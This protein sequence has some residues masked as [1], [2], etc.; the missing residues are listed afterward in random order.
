MFA[1]WAVPLSSSIEYLP[2][3]SKHAAHMNQFCTADM[4]NHCCF[5]LRAGPS[6]SFMGVIPEEHIGSINWSHTTV[7]IIKD[8]VLPPL[9]DDI[10]LC[11]ALWVLIAQFF[12]RSFALGACVF[13]LIDPL[14]DAAVAVLVAATIQ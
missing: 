2:V 14:I 8:I 1:F 7:A 4:T 5:S 12:D 13:Y 6:D 10:L 3:V 9:N 11:H